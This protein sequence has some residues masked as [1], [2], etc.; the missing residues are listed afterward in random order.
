[1]SSLSLA[2]RLGL[3]IRFP[4]ENPFIAGVPPLPAM[5]TPF[6]TKVLASLIWLELHPERLLH[7]FPLSAEALLETATGLKVFSKKLL[8]SP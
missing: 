6:S 2:W 7:H 5:S 1:M 4:E 3:E 8:P